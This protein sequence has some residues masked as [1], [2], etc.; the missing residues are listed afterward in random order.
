MVTNMTLK[1]IIG[2][3]DEIAALTRIP[4]D[5]GSSINPDWQLIQKEDEKYFSQNTIKTQQTTDKI[6][7]Q[8]N[9]HLLQEYILDIIKYWIRT[10]S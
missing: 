3:L 4:R 8:S 10:N 7:Y 2:K 9:I 6:P 1:V 5:T